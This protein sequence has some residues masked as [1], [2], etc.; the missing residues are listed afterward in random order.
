MRIIEWLAPFAAAGMAWRA[1][2]AAGLKE[3]E[4]GSFVSPRAIPQMADADEVW[5][6]VTKVPGVRY[7]ALVPNAR[8]AQRAIDAGVFGAPSYVIDGEIFWGQ[9]RLD[10]VERRLRA[11]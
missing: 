7:S 9:D 4:V 8:G 2:A 6:A 5:A 11:G 3:I 10:F 1:M